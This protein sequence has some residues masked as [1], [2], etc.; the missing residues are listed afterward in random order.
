MVTVDLAILSPGT[1]THQ[2]VR[3]RTKIDITDR[4]SNLII[5]GVDED[6]D[7]TV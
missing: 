2:P 1:G 5:F 4:K 3:Q 7:I 6:R